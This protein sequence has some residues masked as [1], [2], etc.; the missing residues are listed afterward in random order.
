MLLI[1]PLKHVSYSNSVCH[2]RLACLPCDT[3]GAA[4]AAAG[5]RNTIRSQMNSNASSIL[6]GL[7]FLGF[8]SFGL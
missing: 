6:I 1:L 2:R 5:V 8:W 7:L 3:S 4:I